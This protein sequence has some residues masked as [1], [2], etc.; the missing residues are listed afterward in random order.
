ML[1]SEVDDSVRVSRG[2]RQSIGIVEV[3]PLD[4]GAGVFEALR[5]GVGA[6]EADY[7]VAGFD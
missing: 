5:R 4:D 2:L 1:K 6:G 7:V 3:A